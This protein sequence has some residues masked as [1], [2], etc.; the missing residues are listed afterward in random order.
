MFKPTDADLRIS[1]GLTSTFFHCDTCLT[2]ENFNRL[3][4]HETTEKETY[5]LRGLFSNSVSGVMERGAVAD[6]TASKQAENRQTK[7]RRT[8][9]IIELIEQMRSNIERMKAD[10]KALENL[11][12]KRDG[13]AWREKLALE[14][15]NEDEI[16]QRKPDE[17]IETYRK[18]LGKHLI[19][20]MLNPDG[21]IKDK[22]K[23]HPK[24]GDYAEWAQ[25]QYHL[26]NAKAL[27]AELDDVNTTPQRRE[28][29]LDE[30]KERGYLEKATFAD[31]A[32]QS[33]DTEASIRDVVDSQR[34]ETL[35]QARSSD[36]AIKFTS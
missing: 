21:S 10:I 8:A 27:S 4:Q 13:D 5:I 2:D 12:Q 31:R 9:Q 6:N 28:K 20:E 36:A 19:N 18:R 23:N 7:E 34:D 30:M 3:R 26:N 11:F 24:Y 1:G 22:Y 32:T 17:D 33:K 25:K 15:L 29:I 35:S 16:P 14:I